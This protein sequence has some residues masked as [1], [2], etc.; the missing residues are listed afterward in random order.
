MDNVI[1]R[2]RYK[3]IV[4]LTGAGISKASGLQTFRGA[5]GIWSEPDTERLSLAESLVDE[6]EMYWKFWGKLKDAA[7][8]ATPNEGHIALAMW[9][10]GLNS[11]QRFLLITQNVDDLHQ[12]AGSRNVAELHGSLYR[13]RCTRASCPSKPYRD[14]QFYSSEVPHCQVCGA[15]LRPD[16]VMFNEMLPADAEHHA[17]RA[18]RDCDLFIAI[19][20]SGNVL[21]TGLNMRNQKR[22]LS[23][24]M[25]RKR[26]TRLTSKS[27]DYQ[28]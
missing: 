16:V 1:E 13:T 10:S 27:K 6:P 17:K 5:D 8:R 26:P 28:R 4:V 7:T 20:T 19:G 12:R 15:V 24:K 14:D 18:L 3:S 22:C 23:I 2:R 9:E 11:D 25:S 21:L